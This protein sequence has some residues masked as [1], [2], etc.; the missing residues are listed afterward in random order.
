[1][2]CACRGRR[3][4]AR[5]GPVR[6]SDDLID[7]E[8]HFES[9]PCHA[10]PGGELRVFAFRY[11]NDNALRNRLVRRMR[12]VI[13]SA[14]GSTSRRL[15]DC[16]RLIARRER[17]SRQRG[18]QRRRYYG[19]AGDRRVLVDAVAARVCGAALLATGRNSW[20]TWAPR[21]RCRAA[22]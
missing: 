20:A 13:E 2:M 11:R 6:L 15:T 1:M 7:P 18:L 12:R 5:T 21:R 3:Q 10:R 16:I 4:R 9:N 8:I 17:R 19:N 22:R 14:R